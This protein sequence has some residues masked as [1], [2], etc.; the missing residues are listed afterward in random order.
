MPVINPDNIADI[1]EPNNTI[2]HS[3]A[4][5]LQAG[6]QAI[7]LQNE[8]LNNKES[9]A[10]ETTLSGKREFNTLEIAKK[11]GFKC[12]LIYVYLDNP[13]HNIKRVN[14]RTL[15]KGHFVDH[16]D[17]LRR[18]ERSF[19]N[20]KQCYEQFDRVFLINNVYNKHRLV[21]SLENNKVKYLSKKVDDIIFNNI[22]LIKKHI[23]IMNNRDTDR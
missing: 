11:N 10:I 7:N 20:L 18:Y 4:V 5:K 17:I 16:N 9:F 19:N 1:L 21:S 2:H 23:K 3:E 22:P 12:N 14:N 13:I 8:C 15:K 6:K